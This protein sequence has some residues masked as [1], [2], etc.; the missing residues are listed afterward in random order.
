MKN[1]DPSFFDSPS[2]SKF[3]SMKY[4]PRWIVLILDISLSVLA[5]AIA[6]YVAEEIKSNQTTNINI[7]AF[8]RLG[9]LMFFQLIF[10]WSFHTYSGVLRYSSF[11]DAIKIFFSILFNVILISLINLILTSLSKGLFINYS[12]LIIYGI[13]SFLF[14][15]LIRLLVKSLYDHLTQRGDHIT[16]VMIYGTK[17]AAIGIGKMLMSEQVGSKYKL[18]GFIDDDKSAS[19]KMIMGVKVYHLNEESLKNVIVKKCKS[20]II[21]PVKLTQVNTSNILEKFIDNNL[22]ILSL[23]PMNI[24]KSD[25]P[26]LGQI[27]SIQIEDLLE[28]PQINISTDNI[29]SQLKDKVVLVTGAAGSI[30]SEIA[31]QV[32]KFDTK[33]VVLLDHAESPM[34]DLKLDL[35]EKYEDKNVT[36]FLGDVRN[37]DRMDFMMDLY[38]PDIIYHAAAYKHVPMMEDYPVESVQVNVLGTKILADLA[39]K[40]RVERFVMVSTDKAVNPTNV[41]GA[42][43][44]IAE[45]YVQSL[46]RKLHA[47]M[48]GGTTKFITTRFGNVLGSSGSVIPYFKKQIENGGPVTVTHPEI[49]RYFMT[50]PEACMLVLEAG[51]MGHGGEIYIFDMGKPVKIVDLA[52]KMIRLAG[53]VPEEDIKIVY[54]GLRPGEKL[55]EELLNKKE[56]TQNTHHPKIMIANVQQYDFD[57]VSVLIDKLINYSKLCK[58]YLTVSTMKKIVPEF[59]SKNSQY[60]RLDI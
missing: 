29:A 35:Q 34:H 36:V 59:K 23:P 19:E 53:Y 1:V 56:Y 38:R 45:I 52:R 31:L 49:I 5:Y 4:L 41:M 51:S 47:T 8:Q 9:F 42:S 39:V 16:P 40:Y 3:V 27:K 32:L 28:R 7:S 2:F 55:F 60:E 17:S 33:L 43:K 50:I 25:I 30:G 48:N 54:S 6:V 44:R 15:F 10:Y 18:V 24:W 58:D 20:I 12:E 26:S 14:L 13:L 22:T 57:K 21:S 37:K 46:Y 11:V